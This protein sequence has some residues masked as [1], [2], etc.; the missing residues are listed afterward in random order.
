MIL[1]PLHYLSGRDTASVQAVGRLA[2]DE[3]AGGGAVEAGVAKDKKADDD[4]GEEV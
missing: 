4:E 1:P 2:G 3:E